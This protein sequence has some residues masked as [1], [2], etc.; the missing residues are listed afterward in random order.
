MDIFRHSGESR[1][2]APPLAAEATSLNEKLAF[3]SKPDTSK[4]NTFWMP[5]PV[6]H[7]DF[8]TFYESVNV[9]KQDRFNS[10]LTGNA[11]KQDAHKFFALV[12]RI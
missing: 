3:V 1:N 10:P 7:D 5:D 2:P 9:Q 12:I 11:M 6:R 4:F 8:E